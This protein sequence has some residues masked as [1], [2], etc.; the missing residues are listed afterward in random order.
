MLRP[1]FDLIE[2]I[3][4]TNK[5]RNITASY[6]WVKGHQDDLIEHD[7]LSLEA[8]LNINADLQA[9]DWNNEYGRILV[10]P[11]NE[12][13]PS[14][15]AALFINKSMVTSKYY[16]RLL[17]TYTEMQ[18]MKYLQYRFEWS[19]EIIQSIAWKSFK[20]GIK[21]VN[22]PVITGKNAYVA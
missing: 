5:S 12:L 13:V 18:Y 8:R 20:S 1:E 9:K 3:Y 22:R 14:N 4:Q 19:D 6:T 10:D 16:D 2:E 17:N 21:S 11:S 7:D 15:S